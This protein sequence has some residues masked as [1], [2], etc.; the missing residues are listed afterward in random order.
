MRFSSAIV[1]AVVAALASSISATPIDAD[2]EH[3]APLCSKNSECD[4]C[5]PCMAA[6]SFLLWLSE[7]YFC[8]HNSA[9]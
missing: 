4:T 7:L 9:V 8:F 3:C 6:L 2:V 5:G 1:L